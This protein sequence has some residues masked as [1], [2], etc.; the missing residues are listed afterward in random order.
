VLAM[1][2]PK[3]HTKCPSTAKLGKSDCLRQIMVPRK[4]RCQ[5]AWRRKN[6]PTFNL[7]IGRVCWAMRRATL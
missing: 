4:S 3:N 1:F 7:A 2:S 6:G 5:E